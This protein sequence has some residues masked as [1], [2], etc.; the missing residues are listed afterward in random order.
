MVDY[1]RILSLPLLLRPQKAGDSFT[2]CGA[3]GDSQPPAPQWKLVSE[4]LPFEGLFEA[5]RTDLV[6]RPWLNS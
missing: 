1:N 6:K 4:K 5:A 2:S 3:T